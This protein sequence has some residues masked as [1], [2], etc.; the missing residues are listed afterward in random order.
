MILKKILSVFLSAVIAFSSAVTTLSCS[1]LTAQAASYA[2]ELKNMGFPDSYIDDLVALKNK[3]PNWIFKPL[4]TGLDWKAAVE[5]ERS[6]HSNQLIQKSSSTSTSMYCSCSSCYKNGSYVIQEASNWVSASAKAVEYY[7]DPRNWLSEKYIFQFESNEYDGTQTIAGIETILNGTWMHNAVITY[8]DANGKTQTIARDANAKYSGAILRAANYSGLSAYY[9]AS[10]IRQEVGGAKP[11]AGGASG[12]NSTYPGIYN[13]YNIGAYTGAVDGLKWA[14]ASPTGYYTNCTCRVRQEPTTSSAELVMLAANTKVN[15]ISTTAKKSDGYTWYNI[16]VTYNGKSYNGYIRSDLVDHKTTDTYGRPWTDPDKSIFYG[17][18]YIANNFKYQNTGYLQK[19]NVNP[20]SGQLHGHEYMANVAAAAA[21]S[22]TT[23]NAYKSANIM[24]VTKTFLIPVFKKMPNDEHDYTSKVL[25]A[26]TTTQDGQI[27]YTCKV[28]GETK[29][30]TVPMASTIKL[31]RTS[32]EC[33][34]TVQRPSVTVTDKNGKALTYK[35]DF[36]VDYSNWNSKDVGK[37]TVTVKLI[38]KYSGSKTYSYEI[39]QNKKAVTPELSR[40]K[41]TYCATVQRPQVTVYNSYGNPLEYKKDF[42]VSF[43][44]LNSTNVGKYSVTVKTTG[45]NY[46]SQSKTLSYE[47]VP[48]TD[49]TPT[50]SRTDITYTGTVQRPTVTVKDKYGNS[51]VYKKD[52]TV[53]YSN[54]SSTD[55]GQY[56]VTVK[57]MGNYSGELTCPYNINPKPTTLSNPV[58]I[59]KGFTVNWNKQTEHTTGYQIQYATKSDF[60][61]AATVYGGPSTATSKTITGRA[62]KTKYYVRV[63]T[64]KNIKGEYFFS[65]WSPAKS[66]VTL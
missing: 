61:N 66:V 56:T 19:F 50:L 4:I 45:N 40:N 53:D 39:Y 24:G 22:A 29:T 14:A 26:A 7:M 20:A 41:I 13:Y 42:T 64:Y 52:F 23:Y 63:R 35:T 57:M 28:C 2:S 37:Y 49:V 48:Q 38:G 3:Y 31:N 8:K 62:G 44:N 11:T 1:T 6:R 55:V 47:I 46:S 27:Q 21:E 12:T 43:S 33:V 18:R 59:S 17:A 60:S 34:G 36:T 25:K 51:L 16:S 5:G 54:W 15:Y 32:I 58:A 9:L 65:S 10:K 30:E